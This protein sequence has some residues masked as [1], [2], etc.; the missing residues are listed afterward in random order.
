MYKLALTLLCVA[1]ASAGPQ[2]YAAPARTGGGSFGG[3]SGGGSFGGGSGGG[4]FGGGSFGGGSGGGGSGGGSFGGGSFGGGSG[5]GGAGGGG[6]APE[7]T[8]N[9][10]LYAAPAQA[11]GQVAPASLPR[12]K[13][14]YNF[15]F[16]RTGG[17]LGGAKP[18]VAPAP[19]QKTLVYVL[20][21]RPS[22]QN[23]QVIEVPHTP[24]QPEVFF[25]NYDNEGDNTQLPGGVS[26][27]EALSQSAQQGQVI[28]GGSGGGSSGGFSSGG[29]GGGFSGGSGGGFSGG[30][31]FSSGGSGGGFS[32]GVGGGRVRGGYA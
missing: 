13:V 17:A 16:V 27:Q 2:G 15:V 14:H 19:Q 22:A 23:Q 1:G 5:G 30:S 10:Y 24:T 31:S 18:L 8:R 25:V 11:A 4:S 21:K 28:Q 6:G 29:S 9:I 26:L 7:I 20:S 12:R 3:S 32:G